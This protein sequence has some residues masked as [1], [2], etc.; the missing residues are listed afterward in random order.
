[1]LDD[2]KIRATVSIVP[3][4][5]YARQLGTWTLT[6]KIASGVITSGS[7]IYFIPQ[8]KAAKLWSQSQVRDPWAENYT[9]VHTD[10]D[11]DLEFL[12]G[13]SGYLRGAQK[14]ILGVVVKRGSIEAGNSIIYTFGNTELGSPGMRMFTTVHSFPLKVLL[15]PAN[16]DSLYELGSPIFH[17]TPGE[18]ARV[19][20]IAPSVIHPGTDHLLRIQISDEY[21]NPVK[22]EQNA[23][24]AF[25]PGLSI[26]NELSEC[27]IAATH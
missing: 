20:V 2:R 8:Q 26:A 12:S 13:K 16:E 3:D 15:K 17:I 27:S 6:C 10:A 23:E 1:M 5:A 22:V 4:R 9:T 21:G 19:K 7:E 11:A 18:A 24:V 14:Y 25:V